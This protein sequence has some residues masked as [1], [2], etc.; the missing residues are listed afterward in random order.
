MEETEQQGKARKR[1]VSFQIKAEAL[2]ELKNGSRPKDV[3]NK[4]GVPT[5]TLRGWRLD[6]ERILERAAD[7]NRC[8][9]KRERDG[10][11]KNPAK[12]PV[13]RMSSR[14]RYSL[15]PHALPNLCFL[16]FLFAID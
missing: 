2:Q 15:P 6:E 11:K 13:S 14:V 1:Y 5:S 16:P 8:H 9:I 7:P 12:L 4:F 10:S 3:S